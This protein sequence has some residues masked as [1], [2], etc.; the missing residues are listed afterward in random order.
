MFD[1]QEAAEQYESHIRDGSGYEEFEVWSGESDY[2]A[3]WCVS[4]VMERDGTV[5]NTTGPYLN[6]YSQLA[7]YGHSH[8]SDNRI[9]LVY[10]SPGKDV[11][12]AIKGANEMRTQMLA[13]DLWPLEYTNFDDFQKVSVKFHEWIAQKRGP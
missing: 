13:L 4:V 7:H 10:Y 2:E 8:S 12:T 1:D 9:R 6:E 3:Q 11:D 5:R